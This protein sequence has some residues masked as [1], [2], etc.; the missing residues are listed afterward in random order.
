VPRRQLVPPP[1]RATWA[2]A[3]RFGLGVLMIPLGIAI[4]ARAITANIISPP[5]VLISLAFIAFGIY[6]IYVG[7]VRYRT[8]RASG[9][10]GKVN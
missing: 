3:Y 8:Y 10:N 2:D 6:R 7:I 4:L 1:Q 5:A 9:K